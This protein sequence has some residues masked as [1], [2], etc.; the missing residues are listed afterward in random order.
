MGGAALTAVRIETGNGREPTR[1]LPPLAKVCLI[2]PLHPS[3]NPRL[4][5]EADALSAA[6]YQVEVIAPEFSR[7]W[8]AA[9]EEFRDRAWRIVARPH[10]GP[11]SPPRLRVLELARRCLAG[12]AAKNFHLRHPAVVRAAWHPVA[13][14]LVV[15]ARSVKADLYIA[16]LVAALP[17][18]AIAAGEHGAI[19]GFDAEDFHLGDPPSSPHHEYERRLTRAIEGA[20]LPGCSY[21]TAASPLIAT[22]YAEAY[23]IP[24]PHV[25]LNVFPRARAVSRP[26]PAGV[27]K[28]GPSVYWFSQTI[29]PGRGLECAVRAIA[30]ARSRPHLY[31]RGNA[32]AGYR[33]RIERLAGEEGVEDRVHI[34]PMANPSQMEELASP[35]DVG[36]SGEPGGTPNNRM[37][38][39]NKLFSYMLAGLPIAMS[40]TPA[41]EAFAPQLGSAARL[42]PIDDASS[43]ARILDRWLLDPAALAEA[44]RTSWELGQKRFNWDL[45]SGDFLSTIRHALG[46]RRCHGH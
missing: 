22:A 46:G 39:G 23:G 25:L 10:F 28:P 33:H 4:V 2:T 42:Y 36:L 30:A 26:T 13:P 14:A 37:A 38:L 5:K 27:C 11:E 34:L 44:R 43:L 32:A 40:A 12:I 41:H 8:R 35:Y 1:A 15:A 17:A 7:Q 19:Y 16:H 45:S 18:A 29:G 9:D 21:M 3:G 20:H 31:L 6:G 24:A